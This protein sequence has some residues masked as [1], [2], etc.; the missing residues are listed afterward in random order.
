[1]SNKHFGVLRSNSRRQGAKY[2]FL[3]LQ[4][5]CSS[6]L[7]K[8]SGKCVPNYS[9]DQYHCDCS[10][11]YNGDH[12]ETGELKNRNEEKDLELVSSPSWDK[13]EDGTSLR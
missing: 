3:T 4:T 2:F 1:M 6:Y 7:C 8:N 5:P 9:D 11:G 13:L 10:P 12:C